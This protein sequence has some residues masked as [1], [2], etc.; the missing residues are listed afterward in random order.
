MVYA[1][2]EIVAER[3]GRRRRQ[4]RH[5]EPL[6]ADPRGG[7][8]REAGA[9]RAGVDEARR[10]GREPHRQ[11]RRRLRRR[12]VR[13]VRRPA[14]AA[15]CSTSTC[16][17]TRQTHAATPGQGIAK[18]VADYKVVGKSLPRI[19]IPDKV[20]GQVHVHP[21]RH[22]SRGWCTHG[23]VR[24]R[25]AGA[26]TSQNHFPLE[27]RRELDQAHPGRP[28]RADQQLH[29]RRRAEGVRRDPGRGAAQGRLEERSEVCRAP[30][31]SGVAAQGRRHE[32]A[33]TRPATRADTGDV[34]AAL[35]SA[36]KTVSA[37]YMYQYNS[38]MP[39]GPHCAIA[40]VDAK[41]Q[42]RATSSVQAQ[43]ALRGAPGRTLGAGWLGCPAAEQ[44]A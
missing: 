25:G 17:S 7:G 24:P 9:A 14:S 31:T 23:S 33:R 22:A 38:F 3:D 13:Q 28:G 20:I 2:P 6:D 26:N 29:R 36:A 4:R 32:H 41:D 19:D 21:E 40:D 5:L 34:D 10:P 27:R 1:H 43:Q 39:I 11:Q 30:A 42:D 44:S 37:T 8:V 18:P 15:S 35:A 16:P 12:Q